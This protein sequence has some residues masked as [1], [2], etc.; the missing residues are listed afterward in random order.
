MET[1]MRHDKTANERETDPA[2]E[3]RWLEIAAGIACLIG[4]VGILALLSQS[5]WAADANP[6]AKGGFAPGSK[7]FTNPFANTNKAPSD[8]NNNFF[9]DEDEDDGGQ[10]QSATAGGVA[11]TAGTVNPNGTIS[12]GGTTPGGVIEHNTEPL[13]KVDSETGEGSK[14]IVTDFNFP[15]ADILDIAK[16][17]GK[18]SGKNFILD[19]DVKG[20]ITIIS[21]SP[22]TVGDAWRSFL[23]AH[24][25]GQVFAHRSPARRPRQAAENL[26]RGLLARHRRANHARFPAEIHQRRRS[27]PHLPQLHAGQLAHH[28]LRAD[29]HGDRDGYRLE[30]RQ[31]RQDA[32]DPR[33]RRL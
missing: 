3:L 30:H 12:G 7:T 24:P 14:E 1:T 20:R 8:G 6:A 2:S 33:H 22:I 17:L 28:R 29:E 16:T 32:R 10:P 21:N 4:V 9:E 11:P 27:R 26:R 5:S 15:D 23:T 18:L 31:A 13:I 19:K 25:V